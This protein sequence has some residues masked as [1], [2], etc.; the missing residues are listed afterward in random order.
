MVKRSAEQLANDV[1]RVTRRLLNVVENTRIRA[2]NCIY[3]V[4]NAS[5]VQNELTVERRSGSGDF[6]H[7]G[8]RDVTG[9]RDASTSLCF[10]PNIGGSLSSSILFDANT[11]IFKFGA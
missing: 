1:V 5:K 6:F 7:S 3:A 4:G 11:G 9:N 2:S 10:Y 8:P